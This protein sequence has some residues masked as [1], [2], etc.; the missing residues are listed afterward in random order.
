MREN[1][2]YMISAM[3]TRCVDP[4]AKYCQ[5]CKYGWIKYSDWVETREDL[6]GCYFDSGC[7]YGLEDTRPTEE[8]LEEFYRWWDEWN[9]AQP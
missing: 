3:P 1:L 4:V 9:E 7:I 6:D 5:G 2:E 8:E